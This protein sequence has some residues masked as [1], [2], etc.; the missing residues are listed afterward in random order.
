MRSM[1]GIFFGNFTLQIDCFTIQN[2]FE[3]SCYKVIPS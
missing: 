2:L 1:I 3:G